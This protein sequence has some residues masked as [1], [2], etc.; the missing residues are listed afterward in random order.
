MK[1]NHSIRLSYLI[2]FILVALLLGVSAYLEIYE[3]INPCSLCILQRLVMG[4]LG[5]T[6]FLGMILRLNKAGQ[7]I[8]NCISLG[9]SILG[10]VLSGRQVWLQHIRKIAKEN[11]EFIYF[12]CLKFSRF[13]KRSNISE[14][15]HGMFPVWLAILHLS[16]AEWSLICLAFFFS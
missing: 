9:V 5:V 12:T 10:L 16:L 7:L 2:S 11:A 13:L 14:G 4:L 8:I 6:F 15:R 1:H 3:G